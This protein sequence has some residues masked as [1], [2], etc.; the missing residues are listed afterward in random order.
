MARRAKVAIL[1][2]P[3]NDVKHSESLEFGKGNLT[4]SVITITAVLTHQFGKK[5]G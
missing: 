5:I 2:Q 4:V 1:E 3:K